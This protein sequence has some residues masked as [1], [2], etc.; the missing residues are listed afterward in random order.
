VDDKSV[1]PD[2]WAAIAAE[3]R[4]IADDA[5][6]LIGTAPPAMVAFDMQPFA[7]VSHPPKPAQRDAIIE[8]VNAAANAFLGKDAKTQK[9]SDHKSFH[10]TAAGR[11]GRISLSIYQAI[12]DPDIEDVQEELKELRARIAE[13][14]AGR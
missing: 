5:E 12:A 3:L 1:T 14:E 8:A 13:L 9:M 10:H 2:P 7:E 11:R 6:K 4:L